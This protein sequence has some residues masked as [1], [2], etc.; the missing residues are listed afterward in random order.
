[1][2]HHVTFELALHDGRILRTRISRPVNT[3]T[4]GPG[5]WRAILRE[6]L[7]VSEDEFWVCVNDK[8]VPDRG[9]GLPEPSE[10]ALPAGLVYQLIHVAGVA[11]D[12]VRSMTLAHALSVLTE[13][14]SQPPP[15]P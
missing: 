7:H 12:D 5:L 11:E 10:A 9:Q 8:Q 3:T 1:M 15:P 13:H 4:Y 2:R 14:W 6:Q